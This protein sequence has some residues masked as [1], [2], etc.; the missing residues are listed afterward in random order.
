MS[1]AE[2]FR[3][4]RALAGGFF[5]DDATVKVRRLHS[6]A[7]QGGHAVSTFEVAQ[8]AAL[9]ATTLKVRRPASAK[10]AGRVPSGLSVAVAGHAAPYLTASAAVVASD[11][12]TVTLASP[13]TAQATLG[14]GVT[15]G[16]YRET[17]FPCALVTSF[18]RRMIDGERI[19]A[20]DRRV[21]LTAFDGAE[22]PEPGDQIVLPGGDVRGI[23]SAP[24]IQAGETVIGWDVQAGGAR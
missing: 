23:V 3:E 19:L 16:A 12:L 4:A 13:L 2:A 10:L 15:V 24:A 22:A 18:D 8:T 20:D 11:V 1:M 6:L 21:Q 9:G 5:G 14:D 7:D 17:S